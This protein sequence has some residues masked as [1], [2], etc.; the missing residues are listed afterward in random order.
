[1]DRTGRP[2]WQLAAPIL[3][4]SAAL[5][6]GTLGYV[7]IEGWSVADAIFM[8]VTTVTTVGYGEVHPLSGWG[9]VLTISLIL[10]GVGCIT[11]F[12]GVVMALVF[13][14]QLNQK[15]ERRRM[16]RH[17]EQISDHF[18]ICGYGRVGRQIAFEL[19][20]ERRPF[21]VIDVNQLSLELA[22]EDGLLGEPGNAT[23]DAVLN[24]AGIMRARALITAV[25]SD[26]DNI[27]VTL[28]A[29]SLRPDLPIVARAN[30]DDAAGKLRRAGATQVVSPYAMAGRQMARLAVRPSTVD[31]VETLLQGV[32][33]DLLLE[34]IRVAE[35][36][37]LVGV[38]TLEALRQFAGGAVLLA[39]Q[40]DGRTTAPAP[41]DFVLQAGDVLAAV[42][43]ET[44]L[45]TLELACEGKA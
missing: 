20:R 9:R 22:S 23:E 4:L 8:V 35:G 34:D 41:V 33:A 2:N 39:V 11:Y 36:S 16:E 6:A 43:T 37:R 21:A 32:D 7:L 40:R 31:F 3:A 10:V 17:I 19:R 24:H 14:G 27:F 45:H 42:G 12:F 13:E 29:R 38:S 25:A 26:A 15:L 5:A 30:F 28:S 44:Q 18:I 1:M